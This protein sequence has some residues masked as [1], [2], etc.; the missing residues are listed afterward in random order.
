MNNG[1][2]KLL[3][4]FR[5][6]MRLRHLSKRTEIAYIKWVYDFLCF[7]KKKN[8]DWVHPEEMGDNEVNEYLTHL[9]VDRNVAASTQ[10][11]AVS[12]LL[13]LYSKILKQEIN[14][15]AVRAKTP[16]RVPVVLSVDEV[17]RLLTNIP[18]GARRIMAGIMYGA[19]LR[20]M[21]CCRLRI[22]DVDFE[23][24]QITVRNGK[25]N[26]DR[27]VPLPAKLVP[28]LLDQVERVRKQFNQDLKVG[29]GWVYLPHAFERKDTGAGRSEAWQYL[30]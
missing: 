20:V 3:D 18:Q 30:I 13:F 8:A 7:H 4:Q 26:K 9:A 1:K 16:E 6:Q 28:Y 29:A 2:T 14:F 22:K 12:A 21:E 17:R 15:D 27:M 11:Q 10:N 25:G 24:S 19:G 5:Q 23:R